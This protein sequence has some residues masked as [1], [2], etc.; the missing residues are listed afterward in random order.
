MHEL[1][2]TATAV[3]GRCAAL[4][5]AA[6]CLLAA[7][8]AADG[9]SDRVDGTGSEGV[10]AA[11]AFADAAL[12]QRV[13]FRHERRTT[14]DD[15]RLPAF[16]DGT[17]EVA[18]ARTEAGG[19]ELRVSLVTDGRPRSVPPFPADS[20]HP[21]LLVFLETCVRTMAEMT[22]GSPFYIRNRMRE[23]LWEGEA[24][25]PVEITV[26][27]VAVPGERL[28]IRPFADDPNRDAMGPFAGL[29]LRFVL[30]DAVPGRLAIL[31][32]ATGPDADGAP[33]LVETMAYDRTEGEH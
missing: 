3:A 29:E 20:G 15:P 13:V 17:A 31:E 21:L 6:L 32:A 25:E 8:L 24:T 28:T 5:L 9:A 2:P 18:M 26:D 7:P 12:G 19:R 4:A 30:T 23:A 22:G 11:G 33:Y 1:S 10:F 14:A 16:A 27:G